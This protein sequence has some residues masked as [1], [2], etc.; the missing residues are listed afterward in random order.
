M[1]RD[2]AQKEHNMG[3]GTVMFI[4]GWRNRQ[5][6]RP[7]IL[8]LSST[9]YE[10]SPYQIA[11]YYSVMVD[12]RWKRT[13]PPRSALRFLLPSELK[14]RG[15]VVNAAIRTA[16]KAREDQTE[17]DVGSQDMLKGSKAKQ[18]RSE[19]KVSQQ[20]DKNQIWLPIFPHNP[21][22]QLLLSHSIQ[23]SWN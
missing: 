1:I 13:I 6:K 2:E 7:Y 22:P 20:L 8:A 19:M 17:L 10:A 18:K 23:L 5:F 21:I 15:N 4:Q 16:K 11:G 14:K 12:T 3:H 9:P